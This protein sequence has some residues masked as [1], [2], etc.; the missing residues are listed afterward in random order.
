MTDGCDRCTS[1]RKWTDGSLRT[2][3]VHED[4]PTFLKECVHCGTLWH[5]TLHDMRVVQPDEAH[6]L[7]P[8]A[9]LNEANR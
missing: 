8:D 2:L 6:K 5:E 4:G 1:A 7:Y 3:A 9:D